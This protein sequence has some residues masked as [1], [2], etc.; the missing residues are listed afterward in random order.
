MDSLRA[1]EYVGGL[2]YIRDD[3]LGSKKA[4]HS[5]ISEA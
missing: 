4:I 5:H 2:V 3:R 1:Y